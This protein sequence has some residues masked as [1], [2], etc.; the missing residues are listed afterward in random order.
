M[1]FTEPPGQGLHQ[2]ILKS[3]QLNQGGETMLL[4]KKALIR[5]HNVQSDRSLLCPHI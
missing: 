3:I 5:L 4:T 2:P 1:L